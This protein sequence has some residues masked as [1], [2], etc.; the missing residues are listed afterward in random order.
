[1]ARSRAEGISER[2][3]LLMLRGHG[4]HA[5]YA[6]RIRFYQHNQWDALGSIAVHRH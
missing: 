5:P 2:Q 3:R 6:S 4:W 1:V